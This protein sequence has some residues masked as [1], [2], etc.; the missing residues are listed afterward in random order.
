MRIFY[1]V[2]VITLPKDMLMQEH[3]DT[4]GVYAEIEDLFR[5]KLTEDQVHPETLRWRYNRTA[6][7]DRY[8]KGREL[9][10][11]RFGIEVIDMWPEESKPEEGA[12]ILYPDD[13]RDV[14]E[15]MWLAVFV[16]TSSLEY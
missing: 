9:L 2:P 10:E 3:F 15:D 12:F 11:F 16:A 6:L 7:Y 1:P 4:L 8:Q 13:S 5:G 14:I